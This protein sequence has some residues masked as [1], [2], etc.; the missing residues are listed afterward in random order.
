MSL[1]AIDSIES[2]DE[3][4]SRPSPEAVAA[5]DSCPGDVLVLGAGGKMGPTLARMVRRA[6]DAAG[7]ERRVIAVSRFSSREARGALERAGVETVGGDLLDP[8]FLQFLPECPNVIYMTGMKFGATG[9]EGLTWA[10]NCHLPGLVMDRFKHSRIAAFSTGNVYGLVPVASEGSR[11]ADPLR[12]VGEYAMSCVGRERMIEYGAVRNGT[13][14]AIL[15][16][17]YACELRYGVLVDIAQ[18]VHA[19]EP[20]DL[21]MGYANVIWQGDANAM[22]IAS[23]AHAASPAAVFNIAGPEKL[24]VRETAV[25]FGRLFGIEPILEGVEAPDALLNDGRAAYETLG[26]PTV[27]ADD[28]VDAIARWIAQGG[29]LL[30]KP[31]HYDLRSGAF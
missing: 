20:I 8:G 24:S 31:T 28:L 2:L 25:Q 23:L 18:R 17:N 29:P 10:M 21:A 14:A 11:E 13:P 5:M 15:R 7:P 16:L 26:K 27:S 9:N 12:P 19:R 22:A 4:L 30:G 3:A 6:A 1:S